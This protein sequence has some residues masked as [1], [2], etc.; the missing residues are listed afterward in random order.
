MVYLHSTLAHCKGQSQDHAILMVN[1]SQTLTVRHILL[2]PIHRKSP[3]GFRFEYL[4][5][6]L[7]HS[8][9]QGQ[10]HAYSDSNMSR[11]H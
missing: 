10:G 9:G 3:V 5:L 8:K 4:H 7:A 2:L 6:T 11:K 1:I